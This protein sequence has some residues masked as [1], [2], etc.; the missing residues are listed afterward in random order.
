M[1]ARIKRFFRDSET[2]FFARLQM[3]VGAI[4]TV[5]VATNF[6]TLLGDTVP[7]TQQIVLFAIIFAQGV[8]TEY[9]RRRRADDL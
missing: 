3:L 7:T 5:L 1:W 9:L 4:G 8:A 6:A 2:I